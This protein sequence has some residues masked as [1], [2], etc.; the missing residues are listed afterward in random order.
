MFPKLNTLLG[1]KHFLLSPLP[2]LQSLLCDNNKK[3]SIIVIHIWSIC[4]FVTLRIVVIFLFLSQL[5]FD[6]VIGDLLG[7][8]FCLNV[9]RNSY[10]YLL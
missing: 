6:E 7:W 5:A 2:Q 10:A 3:H 9:V 8:Q 4:L 1:F